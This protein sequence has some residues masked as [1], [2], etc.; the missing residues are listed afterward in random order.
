MFRPYFHKVARGFLTAL[1][2]LGVWLA[3]GE[4][5]PPCLLHNHDL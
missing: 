2:K 3:F 4:T 1:G 5:V